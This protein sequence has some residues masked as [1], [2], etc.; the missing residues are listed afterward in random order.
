M[1]TVN[2]YLRT[3]TTEDKKKERDHDR[4]STQHI[5]KKTYKRLVRKMEI[6]FPGR[7][8]TKLHPIHKS[9]LTNTHLESIPPKQCAN[10]SS[11]STVVVVVMNSSC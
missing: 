3:L 4:T 2:L 7:H 11:N 9:V 1:S 5:L 6:F 8:N 10:S